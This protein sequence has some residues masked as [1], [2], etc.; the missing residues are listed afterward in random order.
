M[1]GAG[2]GR[3][4]AGEHLDGGGFACA[5]GA[6]EAKKLAGFDG[7][8]DVVDGGEAV[9]GASER[10]GG[11]CRRHDCR[12]YDR[13]ESD[14]DESDLHEANL[15]VRGYLSMPKQPIVGLHHVTAIASD[16]QRNLDFYTEVLGLRFVKRTVNFDDPG[17]YHFYFGDDAGSPGTILTFFPWPHAGR[18]L[19]GAGEV[20]HTAFSVPLSSM[21]YWEQRLSEKGILFERSGRRFAE[22]V[23]TLPDPDGMKIEIVGHAD[24]G[25]VKAPRYADV[26]AEHAIR[27]FFGVTMLQQEGK[28]TTKILAVMG[29]HKIAEEGARLRFAA[30][31][32]AQGNHIDIVVEPQANYGRPGAGTVHHIAFRAANDAAQVE[33]REEIGRYIPTTAVLDRDYFHSIYFREPGGVLFELAT[34]NPGF[35]IDEPAESLGEALRVPAWLEARRAELELRLTPITLHKAGVTA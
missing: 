4:E 12:V 34:D 30:H 10:V 28:E 20:T 7:E 25:P 17:T 26:P 9:E 21:G 27:G 8:I 5:V 2:T 33:W 15:N 1:H 6:E 22:E 24:A 14:G 29:F 16:P 35:A 31:G 18:G 32:D 3:E 11:D 23:L 19:A 13:W